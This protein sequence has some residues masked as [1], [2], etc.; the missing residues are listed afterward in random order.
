MS[1]LQKRNFNK[2]INFKIIAKKM[3]TNSKSDFINI[4]TL[5]ESSVGKSSI[6]NRY[7]ENNFDYNFVST[8]GV[9]FRKKIIN[10]NGE[11]IRLKIWDTAG[12]EKFRSIQKQYYRNSD[13]IL[14]VFDVTKFETFNVLEE[15]INSIKNQTSNDIIVVLVGNKIDLNNKVISDDEIKNFAN[16]NKFKYFLTSAATGKNIN[17]VF[18]YI[19]KEIYKIKSKKKKNDSN[20]NNNKNLKKNYIKSNKKACC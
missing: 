19:V 3:S 10:I 11:N 12:Q 9:D 18:D 16:D 13:G 4:I 8:L 15:W 6:I 14:L 20:N 17:E 7:V 1:D 5:G 2:I